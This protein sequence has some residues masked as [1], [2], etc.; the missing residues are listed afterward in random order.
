M[1]ESEQERQSQ[2]EPPQGISAELSANCQTGQAGRGQKLKFESKTGPVPSVQAPG[3][4]AAV[5]NEI[6]FPSSSLP[7][8]PLCLPCCT[9][10]HSQTQ[11]IP[12]SSS[13]TCSVPWGHQGSAEQASPPWPEFQ[14]L[15]GQQKITELIKTNCKDAFY[16]CPDFQGL[17][18]AELFY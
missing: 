2:I 1:V 11:E 6:P 12:K 10:P 7:S 4:R 8:S 5:E 17:C 9:W 13:I 3:A 14:S 15:L 18:L 16:E